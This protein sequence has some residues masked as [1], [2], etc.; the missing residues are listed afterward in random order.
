MAAFKYAF[1]SVRV[2][3]GKVEVV[4]SKNDGVR[5]GVTWTSNDGANT[6]T[7]AKVGS[8]DVVTP[9]AIG[10]RKRFTAHG[11]DVCVDRWAIAVGDVNS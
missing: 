9:V 11:F 5:S 1:T 4:A 6:V 7:A 8:P 2:K 10:E 3:D